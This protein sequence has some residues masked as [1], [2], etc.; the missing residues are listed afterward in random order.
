MNVLKIEEEQKDEYFNFFL[1]T[2]QILSSILLVN[3]IRRLYIYNAFSFA[4]LGAN[5][6][7]PPGATVF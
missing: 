7:P 2:Y 1:F 5:I 3:E 4:S 6:R